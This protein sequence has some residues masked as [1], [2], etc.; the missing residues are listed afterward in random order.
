MRK[1]RIIASVV[2]TGALM[3]AAAPSASAVAPPSPAA[4]VQTVQPTAFTVVTP[5]TTTADNT[6]PATAPTSGPAERAGKLRWV[7]D[8][9]KAVGSKAWDALSSASKKG[10]DAFKEAYEKYIPWVVRKAVEV[11]ATVY[12]I[13]EAVRD[14]VS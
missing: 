2:L 12:E 6:A 8:K 13:Y 9:L 5:S 10:Y 14:F 3:G 1:N 11:G 7:I 4:T